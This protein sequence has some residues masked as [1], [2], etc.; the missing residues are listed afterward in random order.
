VVGGQ[1]Q[2]A[3]ARRY[4]R[5]GRIASLARPCLPPEYLAF[6]FQPQPEE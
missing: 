6:N 3:Q 4:R 5:S 1:V 2:A